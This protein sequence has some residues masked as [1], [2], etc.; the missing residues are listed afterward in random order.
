ML[1]RILVDKPLFYDLM[2]PLMQAAEAVGR[3]MHSD[4]V[5]GM[6]VTPVVYAAG[7]PLAL[8]LMAGWLLVLAPSRRALHDR[9]TGTSVYFA[10][11][12]DGASPAFEPLTRAA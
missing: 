1:F 8:L 5:Q 3:R 12:I 11:A 7:I 6:L 2:R 9:L 10:A 4:A